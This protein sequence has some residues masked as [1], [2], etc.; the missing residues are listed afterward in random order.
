MGDAVLSPYFWGIIVTIEHKLSTE[1]HLE[2]FRSNFE[3]IAAAATESPDTVVPAC[4]GWTCLDV[5]DHVMKGL[6]VYSAFLAMDPTANPMKAVMAES[7]QV[8]QW[9]DGVEDVTVAAHEQFERFNAHVERLDPD[10]PALFWNGPATV[11]TMCWHAAAETWIHAADV[12]AALADSTDLSNGQAADLFDWAVMFRRMVIEGQQ[13]R[14]ES[15]VV[16]ETTDTAQRE[17]LGGGEP[18]AIVRGSATA[19]SLRLWNRPPQQRLEGDGP[20]L[21]AWADV[22]LISP[23]G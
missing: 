8:R 7:S 3:S 12:A 16:L 11:A 18:S 6:P 4:P 20:A 13:V 14:I 19:L 9:R 23:L 22:A 21:S 2:W 5:L 10:A 17:I 15:T 1:L